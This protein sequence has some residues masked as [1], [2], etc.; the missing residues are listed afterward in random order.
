M[1]LLAIED[2]PKVGH[3]FRKGLRAEGYEKSFLTRT[4]EEVFPSPAVI[5]GGR[6]PLSNEQSNQIFRFG[7]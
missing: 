7:L 5:P 1:R 4:G 2:E 6:S 3:A